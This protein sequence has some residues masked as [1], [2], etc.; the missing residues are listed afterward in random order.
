MKEIYSKVREE[1]SIYNLKEYEGKEVIIRGS[2]HKIREMSSFRFIILRTKEGLIQCVEETDISIVKEGEWIKITGILVK[3]EKQELGYE[4]KVKN[5]EIVSK[6]KEQMPIIINKK[7]LNLNLVSKL[8]NRIVALRHPKEMAIFKLQEG[9][10]RGFKEFMNNAGFTEIKSPKLVSGSAEGGADVFKINYFEKEVVLAQSPQFYKEIMVGVYERVFEVGAVYRAEKHDTSR[11]IN[12]YISL[13]AEMGFIESFEEIMEIEVALL[14]YI[15]NFLEENYKNEL[16]LLE[17]TLPQITTIPA[18]KFSEIK[19]IVSRE[20]NRPIKDFEDLEPEE[21][22]LIYK[23]VKEKYGSE[24]VF[25]THYPTTKRPFYAMESKENRNE[26][27]SFD[28]LFRGIEIT[29]G[30]Q[31]IHDYDMLEEKMRKR[32]M[33]VEG[34]ESFMALH[35]YGV[36]PHGGL[37]M[38]L[39]RLLAKLVGLENV[40]EASL[41]PRDR[42]RVRP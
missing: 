1:I 23:Y 2:V 36:P 28:L 6:P 24:F 20:Y 41:F 10:I 22:K 30:G 8:D 35:K 39:E 37:G 31:R 16:K 19:E 3:E 14:K 11:H 5:I 18:Y 34:F 12:E 13:D 33:N 9:I 32:G 21:E 38:G 42:N 40:K 29:T 7:E 15:M 26:T 25:V 4:L 17:I 27:E